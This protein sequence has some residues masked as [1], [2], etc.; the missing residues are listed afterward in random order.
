MK[1]S[2]NETKKKRNCRHFRFEA[3][4]KRN[5]FRFDAKKVYENKMKRK[6]R[7]RS[8]NFTAKKDKAK[9]W[10]ICKETKKNIKVCPS[11]CQV[12]T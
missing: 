6:K 2:E 7:K 5:Y 4:R 11:V 10:D 9:F 3:K 12:Y 1:Q 8:E